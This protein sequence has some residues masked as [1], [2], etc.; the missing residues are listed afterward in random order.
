[1][2]F[3]VMKVSFDEEGHPAINDGGRELKAL[4]EKIRSRFKVSAAAILDH[5]SRSGS[6]IAIAALG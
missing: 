3:A 6:A 4:A 1:M 5:G 2:H